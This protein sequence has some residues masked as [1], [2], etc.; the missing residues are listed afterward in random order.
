MDDK[1]DGSGSSEGSAA[2]IGA[3]EKTYT[4]ESNVRARVGL[5]IKDGEKLRADFH[6][7]YRA[8][9]DLRFIILVL[10]DLLFSFCFVCLDLVYIVLP[11]TPYQA[12]VL[13]T[14]NCS[15]DKLEAEEICN[16]NTCI[17]NFF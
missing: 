16:Y 3:I 12:W 1:S 7:L 10:K 8:L 4:K 17:H 11:P 5:Y 9:P 15:N 2:S 14:V 13:S 6:I